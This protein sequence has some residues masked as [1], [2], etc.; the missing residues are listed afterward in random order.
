[1]SRHDDHSGVAN[2]CPKINEIRDWLDNIQFDLNDPDERA[3]DTERAYMLEVLEEVRTMNAELREWGN[4]MY[5]EK[6]DLESQVEAKNG[7]IEGLNDLISW[8]DE[9]ISNLKEQLR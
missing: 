1:M 9:D 2:T 7:E 8:Q 5:R 6:E 4:E 3:L